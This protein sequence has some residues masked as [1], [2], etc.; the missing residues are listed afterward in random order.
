M[1]GWPKI[2][3]ITQKYEINS[4]IVIKNKLVLHNILF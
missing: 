2:I 3:I 4:N 1:N